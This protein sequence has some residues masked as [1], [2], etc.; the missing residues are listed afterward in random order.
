MSVFIDI[1]QDFKAER[2][3]ASLI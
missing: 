2:D 3:S 1:H